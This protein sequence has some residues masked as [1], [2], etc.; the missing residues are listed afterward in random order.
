M[1]ILTALI[2]GAFI[3]VSIATEGPTPQVEITHKVPNWGELLKDQKATKTKS[4]TII[5]EITQ[6]KSKITIEYDP[7]SPM[8][9]KVKDFGDFGV[10]AHKAMD[11]LSEKLND[12]ELSK[13]YLLASRLLL[14]G[15]WEKHKVN[16]IQCG[17]FDV[18]GFTVRKDS[19]DSEITWCR[20]MVLDKE[21]VIYDANGTALDVI[22][23]SEKKK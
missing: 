16:S 11:L 1:R 19:I 12:K 4:G 17:H 7:K 13:A 2:L 9:L 20:K 8:T 18:K 14:L 21:A 15:D 5:Y 10:K 3:S 22:D 6:E 23:Y